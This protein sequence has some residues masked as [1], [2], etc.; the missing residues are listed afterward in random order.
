MKGKNKMPNAKDW[1]KEISTRTKDQLTMD[2]DSF[3]QLEKWPFFSDAFQLKYFGWMI[4]EMEQRIEKLAA[5]EMKPIELKAPVGTAPICPACGNHNAMLDHRFVDSG[6]GFKC[7]DC[8]YMV[9]SH[10]VVIV[11]LELDKPGMGN[12]ST[13]HEINRI[14]GINF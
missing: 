14:E 4:P 9:R 7:R 1:K 8:G 10:D 13:Y 5:E 2:L 11:I 3:K 6:K 12:Q